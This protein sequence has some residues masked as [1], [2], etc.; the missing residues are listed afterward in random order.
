MCRRNQARATKVFMK[1]YQNQVIIIGDCEFGEAGIYEPV[2]QIPTNAGLIFTCPFPQLGMGICSRRM[3]FW[4][5]NRRARMVSG[6]EG[7]PGLVGLNVCLNSEAIAI[8]KD[9]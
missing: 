3:S 9:E 5:W 2:P 4:P 8:I 1:I 7:S 6:L